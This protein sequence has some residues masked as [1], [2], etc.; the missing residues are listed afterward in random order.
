MRSGNRGVRGLAR[1]LRLGLLGASAAWALGAGAAVAAAPAAP[2]PDARA[3]ATVKAMTQDEKLRV[4]YGWFGSPFVK[5]YKPPPE[6]IPGSAGYVP[7]VP[8]LGVPE[9]FETDA[10][11]GVASQRT[12]E[13]RERFSVLAM[14]GGQAASKVGVVE[15]RQ[16][17]VHEG[18]AMQQ[19][20]RRRGGIGERGGVVSAR[21]RHRRAQARTNARATGE[22]GVVDRGRELRRRSA[23]TAGNGFRERP[24][25]PV[26]HRAF[27]GVSAGSALPSGISRAAR[28]ERTTLATRAGDSSWTR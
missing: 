13:H 24:F 9:Q 21:R 26:R 4:V 25:D 28:K 17:V 16:V 12:G 3:A 2:D 10:G 22:Y 8:R 11:M 6:A 14:N 27:S 15:A 18:R 19:L 1:G 20:E 5:G 7:G 23:L